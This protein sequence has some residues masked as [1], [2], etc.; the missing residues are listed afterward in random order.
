MTHERSRNRRF[1]PLLRRFL[2]ITAMGAA[3]AACTLQTGTAPRGGAEVFDSND[4]IALIPAGQSPRAL[5]ARAAVSGFVL[6]EDVTL[7]GLGLRMLRYDFPPAFSGQAAIGVLEQAEPQATAGINHL[8]AV[9]SVPGVERFDYATGLLGWPARGCRARVAVGLIDTRVDAS[10]ARAGLGR[11]ISRDFTRDAAPSQRHGSDVLSVLSNP[12]V[13]SRA[14]IY[15]AAAIGQ[16][17]DGRTATGVDSLIKALDWLAAQNVRVVNMS[18]AGPY[19][20]LL[21]RSVARAIDDGMVIVAAA[22]NDGASA[23][24]RYPAA[25]DGVIAVTAVDADRAVYRKA[26]RGDHI[27]FAAPGVDIPVVSGS[28]LRFVT[29]TSIAAPFVTARIASDPALSR[30]NARDIKASLTRSA[31]DLGRRGDDPVFGTGLIQ[32]ARSCAP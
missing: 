17:Q 4:I 32:A 3:L 15:S 30:Q 11:V 19:N 7:R 24:P 1:L 14:R 6:R 5:A 26:V 10:V 20:K 22:G 25:F 12:R 28:D 21:E 18:L 8:Y 23:A 27:D 2:L 31:I 29:G 13:M 9:N 16:M